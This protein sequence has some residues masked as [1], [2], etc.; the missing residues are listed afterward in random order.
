MDMATTNQRP[1]FQ[2]EDIE[3]GRVKP[4]EVYTEIDRLK[5]EIN[6]LR[7]CMAQFVT[8]LAT[9]PP[10]QSQQ[11]YYIL[12]VKKLHQV[13]QAISEYLKQYEC[14]VPLIQVAE[15]RL[16]ASNQAEDG[17]AHSQVQGQQIPPLVNQGLRQYTGQGGIAQRR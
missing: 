9:I 14:L 7:N 6:G 11:L 2:L 4:T 13:Q 15:S 5:T 16:G 10:D 12:V 3:L 8:T 1:P 17:V